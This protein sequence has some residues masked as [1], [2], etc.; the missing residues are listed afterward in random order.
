[1]FTYYV[2]PPTT[3]RGVMSII[4]PARSHHIERCIHD[5]W[6]HQRGEVWAFPNGAKLFRMGTHLFG[7]YGYAPDNS[8]ARAA[9]ALFEDARQVYFDKFRRDAAARQGDQA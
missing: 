3:V 8:D 7:V 9:A 6:N 5:E 4:D 1:M 2:L